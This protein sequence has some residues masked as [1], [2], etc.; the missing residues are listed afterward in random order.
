MVNINTKLKYI[1]YIFL[2]NLIYICVITVYCQDFI[3]TSNS[4]INLFRKSSR[5]DSEFKH[6]YHEY[7]GTQLV[8]ILSAN[9]LCWLRK[10]GKI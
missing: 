1:V 2:E 8:L 7:H 5:S 10:L 3:G 6:T 9:I 4:L